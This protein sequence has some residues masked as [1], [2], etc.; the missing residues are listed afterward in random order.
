M[1]RLFGEMGRVIVN[2]EV[3]KC[4]MLR[5]FGGNCV[6]LRGG[7][8]FGLLKCWKY[9]QKEYQGGACAPDRKEAGS[10]FRL[11]LGDLYAPDARGGW[12]HEGLSASCRAERRRHGGDETGH[13][14]AVNAHHKPTRTQ[15]IN[16]LEDPYKG[17]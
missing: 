3:R 6:I 2:F 11:D 1:L 9:E 14:K 12:S 4:S 7:S 15:R 8:A 13:D 10:I 16:R 17:I 5:L